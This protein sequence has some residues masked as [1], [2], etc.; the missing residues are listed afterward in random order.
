MKQLKLFQV[1]ISSFL[2]IST[3]IFIDDV[4]FRLS[5]LHVLS[6]FEDTEEK[7]QEIFDK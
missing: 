4:S 3:V 6:L 5:F 1:G 7:E 2:K